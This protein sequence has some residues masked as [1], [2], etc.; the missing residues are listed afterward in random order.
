MLK[1]HGGWRFQILPNIFRWSISLQLFIENF[2]HKQWFDINYV[3]ILHCNAYPGK[4]VVDM[5]SAIKDNIVSEWHKV[6]MNKIIRCMY[7]RWSVHNGVHPFIIWINVSTCT[8]WPFIQGSNYSMAFI[9]TFISLV[10]EELW[11]H[12]GSHVP[13]V[14]SSTIW[15]PKPHMLAY[16]V[17]NLHCRWLTP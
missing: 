2:G 1:V 4:K 6:I 5:M 8:W 3:P 7:A 17:C 15:V 9:T 12:M 14:I 16:I 11:S 10:F 13:C